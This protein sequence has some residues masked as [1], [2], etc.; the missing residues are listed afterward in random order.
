M[1]TFDFMRV[2]AFLKGYNIMFLI[3]MFNSKGEIK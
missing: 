1:N 3:M 2:E